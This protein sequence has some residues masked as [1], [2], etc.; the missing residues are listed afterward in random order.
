METARPLNFPARVKIGIAAA[1][2][3]SLWGVVEYFGFESAYQRES[4]DPYRIAAQTARL[5]GVRAALPENAVLGYLTDL[6]PGSIAASTAFNAAQY[7]LAPRILERG[8]T[9]AQVL[10]NFSR[11]AD[12]AALGRQ[13]GL[14]LERDFQNGVVLFRKEAPK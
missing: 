10:G 8:A 6:E 13:Q 5:E 2:L 9:Q 12:F 11:P 1:T 3:L 7:A 14:R 4:R